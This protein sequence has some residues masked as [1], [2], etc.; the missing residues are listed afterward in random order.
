MKGRERMGSSLQARRDSALFEK[1]KCIFSIAPVGNLEKSRECSS[2]RN[3][4]W[5][6]DVEAPD[7]EVVRPVC[8]GARVKHRMLGSSCSCI[9]CYL[10][11]VG[12]FDW[13]HRTLREC[14]V[15]SV[16]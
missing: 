15:Y 7:A 1:M 10:T 13:K 5:T 9:R 12:V 14:P 6:L 3:T 8:C 2:L 4:H 11:S 16:R